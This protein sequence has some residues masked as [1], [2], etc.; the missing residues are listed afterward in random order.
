MSM[1]RTQAL[2]AIWT[3]NGRMQSSTAAPIRTA[4]FCCA[5]GVGKARHASQARS[6]TR[7][8]S[9][10]C[11]L[12]RQ[13]EDE[14]DEGEDVLVVAAEDAAGEVADVAG[15]ERFDQAE[16]DAADH[17]AGEVAD[18][19]E[20]R[21][22]ERLQAGQEAHRVLHRAVVGGVHDAGERGQ[23][24]ADDEGRRDHGVGLDAHQR[25]DARVLGGGAHRPAEP[26]AVDEVHQARS[27]SGRSR[28]GSGSARC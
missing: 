10:P 27:A 25:G 9:R 19:A 2:P 22:R 11:G 8:P 24:G 4:S 1:M 15:A 6:A 13:H 12:Q 14:D 21:R 26:G 28:P 23:R 5:R 16:Q 17:R 18:A 20:H 7:S 3:T